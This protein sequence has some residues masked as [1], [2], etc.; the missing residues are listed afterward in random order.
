MMSGPYAGLRVVELGRFIAAP[1]CGQLFA[2]GG[3]DVIK[4]EPLSGDDA[5][6]NG[7]RISETEARQFLNKNRGKRSL[8]LQISDSDANRAVRALAQKAD[9]II[10]NF[11]PGQ[12]EKLGL[13][14]ASVSAGN[15][16]VVYAENSAFGSAGPLAG[17][18]GMDALLQG[19]AGVAPIGEDGP[20]LLADPII[21]YTAA[22]LMAWGVASALYH[23]ERTGR[24][25]KL[26]VSLLQA[27][28]VIQN[29]SVN[30]VDAV[31]G[32]RHEYVDYLKDAFAR[33][34]SF[35]TILAHRNTVKPAI[36]PPYYGFFRTRDGLIAIAAGG[37][38]LQKRMADVLGIDDPTLTD[39]T[40]VPDDVAAHTRN[41][42]AQT[43]AAL[44]ENTTAHWMETFAEAVVP[45][46]IVQMKDQILD[47]AQC[48][49]NEY[50]V[51]L[52]HE[53]IG[54]MTV[55]A[56]PVKF[57]ETP[58][59]ATKAS[60]VLGRHSREILG[61]AGL[62]ESEIDELGRRGVVAGLG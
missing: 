17:K 57:A 45:I 20:Q 14:Y 38:G 39:A 1:Y 11:R 50:L 6:R 10:T 32:W 30:H 22:M 51:R 33:G 44:S 53:E 4:I 49:D 24:G 15:P 13:D 26:D 48:W 58:L 18:P 16:A 2:D 5:R 41:L 35:E 46:G 62:T 3:A 60:P 55:V 21:D 34:E 61:E 59:Q 8:A 29:N 42:R 25:Q 9:V 47:D 31:D 19:Y 56:P 54:A 27:A 36:V 23:R 37:R 7:T 40:F 43:E 28:L 52:E 12:G